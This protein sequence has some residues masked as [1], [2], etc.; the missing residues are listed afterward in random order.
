[1]QTQEQSERSRRSGGKSLSTRPRCLVILAFDA[2]STGTVAKHVAALKNFSELDVTLA[3]VWLLN[4]HPFDVDRFD[5]IVLHYSLAIAAGFNVRTKLRSI[6]SASNALKIL[7]I[8]DEYRWIDATADAI[9]DLGISVI[10]TVVN[11]DAV[12]QVYHHEWLKS[13]RK[14]VTL[15]GFVDEGLLKV[16]VRPYNERKI[17]VVYRA[18]KVPYWLGSFAL[19]KWHIGE[20]FRVDAE[21]FNI[22][23]DISSDEQSRIYGRAWIRF[24]ANARATLATESGASI[25]DFSG[26]LRSKVEAIV[27]RDPEMDFGTVHKKLLE[28]IDGRTIIH[29]ISPRIFEAAALRTLMINYPGDYSGRLIPWRHYVPLAKDH[30][31]IEEVVAVIKNPERANAII[32]AAYHEVACDPRNSFRAMVEH[33]DRVAFEELGLVVPA[34]S[35]AQASWTRWR[36]LE[37]ASWVYFYG[38]PIVMS[39]RHRIY[40]LVRSILPYRA[41][42]WIKARLIGSASNQ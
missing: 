1:M 8:Q 10:F 19:E 28:D 20:K 40:M 3:H 30:S 36:N 15:T 6:L 7:F 22:S 23:C 27:G 33:F 2:L 38:W 37:I 16:K 29:V 9:R 35:T 32:D 31:N 41:R 4:E 26:E 34:R 13:V 14:E 11:E 42:Q 12:N 18:R 24:L 17:D 25:C 21:K 5:V 39:A